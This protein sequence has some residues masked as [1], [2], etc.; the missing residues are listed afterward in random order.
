MSD[1]KKYLLMQVLF[2]L[3]FAYMLIGIFP[4]SLIEGDAMAVASGVNSFARYGIGDNLNTY[5]YSSQPGTYIAVYGLTLL[6]SIPS[7]T[8]FALISV[9]SSLGF[10]FLSIYFVSKLSRISYPVCGLVVL[11]FQ[12]SIT[13]SYYPNSNSIAAFLSMTAICL[14]LNLKSRPRLTGLACGVFLALGSIARF[15]ALIFGLPLMWILIEKKS[16]R[17]LFTIMFLA[18]CGTVLAFALFFNVDLSLISGAVGTHFST[19]VAL[20]SL[21]A[22]YLVF[23]SL[24]NLFMILVGLYKLIKYA[25]YNILGLSLTMIIPL[26]LVYS[27]SLTTPKYFYY[28]IPFFSLISIQTF[29]W[30]KESPH[31]YR[32]VMIASIMSG[33]FL[34]QYFLGYQ[35][36]VPR[37]PNMAYILYPH[38]AT[39]FRL[40]TGEFPRNGEFVIGAGYP[41]DTND[42]YRLSSGILFVGEFWHNF[43]QFRSSKVQKIVHAIE[44]EQQ[45][46]EY[47]LFEDPEIL[48]SI[49][50]SLEEKGYACDRLTDQ[51]FLLFDCRSGSHTVYNYLFNQTDRP[52]DVLLGHLSEQ[53]RDRVLIVHA[54]AK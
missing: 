34:A 13:S 17:D 2:W 36:V 8:A 46:N 32:T 3:I 12:E 30:L 5:R 48:R 51:N 54:N 6:A 20:I 18:L 28:T 10:I 24:L 47:V 41:H 44:L 52:L 45:E 39:L 38:W 43:K 25:E 42:N 22:N 14:A 50:S 26:L 49:V 29:V 7:F 31:S 19:K 27:I 15:D 37:S 1:S 23:F 9:L 35:T 11:S 53:S 16:P 21:I 4:A 33:L 40:G